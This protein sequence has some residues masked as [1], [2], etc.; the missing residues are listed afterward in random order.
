MTNIS[1]NVGDKIVDSDQ[2]Y[3][4]F[5]IDD[6]KIYYRPINNDKS[7]CTGS[8]PINNLVQACIRP[9][10]TKSEIKDFWENLSK[11]EPLDIPLNTNSKI[12]N[13]AFLKDVLYS[14]NPIKTA[15][16]LV[17][18]SALKKSLGKLSYSDQSVFDQALGRLVDEV[19]I[20]TETPS[21]KV[22][23][24]ILKSIER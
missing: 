20:V 24:K 15:K 16:L 10:M 12:N 17:Y 8:I 2:A 23:E 18:L 21:D 4:I 3:V 13:G 19:A 5:K 6:G 22:R 9:L 14:N 1:Y 11:E 7:G